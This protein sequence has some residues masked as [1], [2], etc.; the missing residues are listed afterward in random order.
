MEYGGARPLVAVRRA[1]SRWRAALMALAVIP[2]ILACASIAKS[3]AS[4]PAAS[5]QVKIHFERALVPGAVTAVA[6]LFTDKQGAYVNLTGN[7]KLTINGVALDL[8]AA[9][10]YAFS[11][12]PR[13]SAGGNAYTVTYTDEQGRQTILHIPSPRQDFA[14]LAPTAGS[15][16]SI[17][18]PGGASSPLT[19]RY[20]LPYAPDSLP[21][22]PGRDISTPNL[23]Q[24]QM[25]AT[26]ACTNARPGCT[27][28]V[29]LVQIPNAPT[30]AATIDGDVRPPGDGFETLA[31]GPG[32]ISAG[33]NI[34]WNVLASGFLSCYVVFENNAA[35]VPVTWV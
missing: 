16:A 31:P 20:T 22:G 3:P 30:G 19:V 14:I 7:Q 5:L 21:Q 24:V 23:Y 27:A 26:G 11:T 1:G 25:A 10:Y 17:P 28:N 6:V 15:R 9:P 32:A 34:A 33:V 35:D 29:R 13:Q 2:I 8:R 4:A 12:I 18:R